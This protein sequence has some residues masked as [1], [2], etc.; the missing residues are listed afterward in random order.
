MCEFEFLFFCRI[1]F[2]SSVT[3]CGGLALRDNV[4]WWLRDS[5]RGKL[6]LVGVAI[7]K[8]LWGSVGDKI[9]VFWIRII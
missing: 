3:H 7:G 5:S 8:G 1:P 9:G 4:D 6:G 2:P